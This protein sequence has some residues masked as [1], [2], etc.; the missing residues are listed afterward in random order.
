MLFVGQTRLPA[1]DVTRTLL[2]WG[3]TLYLFWL[4]LDDTDHFKLVE[5]NVSEHSAEDH[6]AQEE[7]HFT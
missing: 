6:Y 4:R 1:N 2:T 3:T 5:Q 7:E